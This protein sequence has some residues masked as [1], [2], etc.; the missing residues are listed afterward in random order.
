MDKRRRK[1]SKNRKK[2]LRR[3]IGVGVFAAA[4][5]LGI[6]VFLQHKIKSYDA[7]KI[8]KGIMIGE[9]DVSGMTAKEAEEAVK[10][11]LDRYAV[12]TVSFSVQGEKTVSVSLESMGVSVKQ[13]GKTIEKAVGYGKEGNPV[14]CYRIL[15][16]SEKKKHVKTFPLTYAVTEK[17]AEEALTTAFSPYLKAPEDARLTVKNGKTKLVDDVS[18]EELDLKQTV[19]N[20]NALLGEKRGKTP[21]ETKVVFREKQADIQTEDLADLTDVLGSYTTYYGATGDGRS[22]NVESG[23]RHIGGTLIQ[24]GE[25][26]SANLLMSP[27]TEENG[28]AMAASYAGNEVVESMGGGICQVST[29]L[30]NALLLAELEIVERYEHSMTVSYVDLSMDA[31]IADDVKDLKFKNNLEDPVYIEAALSDGTLTF[32]VFGIETRPAS[33]SIEYISELKETIESDETRY[34]ATEDPVGTMYTQNAGQ[35]GYKAQLWKVVYEDG[36][37]IGREVINYS[38]YLASGK[39]IAVGTFTEDEALSERINAAVQSQNAE[40]IQEAIRS[41][42]DGEAQE[43]IEKNEE[44]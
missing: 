40:K 43:N 37:E 39:T 16:T 32:H 23:A 2:A 14:S 12:Q 6:N 3:I 33:R 36:E 29:T 17:S 9:T 30:Y 31:A 10:T 15:R 19:A 20:V 18:G 34:V 38:T 4:V 42:A 44:E 28:Y 13:L 5:V 21:G 35:T 11:D 25:E 24:P 22:I 7:D 27:Y 8:I 41:L 1:K 26:V